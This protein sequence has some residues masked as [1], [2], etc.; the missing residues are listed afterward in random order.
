MIKQDLLE[1]WS[2]ISHL[3]SPV[4]GRSN[5][6]NQKKGKANQYR[7]D[8]DNIRSFLWAKLTLEWSWSAMTI[9]AIRAQNPLIATL[10]TALGL[11][12]W[13]PRPQTGWG[14]DTLN[15]LVRTVALSPIA[16]LRSYFASSIANSLFCGALF[17][18]S[19]LIH[20]A[21]WKRGVC[22]TFKASISLRKIIKLT[23]LILW[24]SH[25]L[26]TAWAEYRA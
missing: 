14:I 6:V 8:F 2:D 3:A 1:N 20:R 15:E 7:D 4:K 25:P 19:G 24:T 17:A 12:V 10:A 18:F 23:V 21:E 22:G 26:H 9:N 13:W 11:I 16:W 5:H